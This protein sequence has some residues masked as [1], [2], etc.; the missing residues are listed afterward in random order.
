M[1]SHCSI[2]TTCAL[3]VRKLFPKSSPRTSSTLPLSP[4]LRGNTS[5][6]PAPEQ[7]QYLLVLLFSFLLPLNSP[8]L[9]E[10]SPH[11]PGKLS[12]AALHFPSR[13]SL[14]KGNSFKVPWELSRPEFLLL[15]SLLPKRKENRKR[16]EVSTQ[17]SCHLPPTLY[18][19]LERI[20]P[21][22]DSTPSRVKTQRLH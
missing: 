6:S 2:D 9:P 14:M 13:P 16:E 12:S 4:T 5:S 10:T 18:L 19:S 7:G 3:R 21:L 11:T 17:L 22:P 8:G 20:C 1:S 15:H